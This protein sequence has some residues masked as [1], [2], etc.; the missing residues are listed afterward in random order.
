MK[1]ILIIALLV[2]VALVFLSLN[3]ILVLFWIK[4][5]ILASLVATVISGWVSGVAT[6]LVGIVA[7]IQTKKYNEMSDCFIKKQYQMEKCKNIIQTRIHFVNTLKNAAEKYMRKCNPAFMQLELT[8]IASNP[9]GIDVYSATRKTITNYFIIL[10][11]ETSELLHSIELDY[12]NSDIRNV[13]IDSLTNYFKSFQTLIDTE[14]KMDNF[15]LH[16]DKFMDCLLEKEINKSY[17]TA[18]KNLSSYIVHTDMDLNE[19]V[20]YK[21]DDIKFLEKMFSPKNEDSHKN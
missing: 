21:S 6:V 11:M 19:A 7:V 3:F 20:F 16:L 15:C 13:A 1:K 17:S 2:L 4:D 14:K 8:N 12:N 18:E 10:K 5:D 9:S